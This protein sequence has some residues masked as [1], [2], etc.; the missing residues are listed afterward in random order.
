MKTKIRILKVLGEIFDLES[1]YCIDLS[2]TGI[3]LQ[4]KFS[5]EL[6]TKALDHKFIA[7]PLSSSPSGYVELERSN[8][9]IVLT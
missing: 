9:E 1:F 7:K 3:R 4:S 2:C 8:I 6:V 5:P